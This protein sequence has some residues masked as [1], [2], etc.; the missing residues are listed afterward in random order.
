MYCSKLTPLFQLRELGGLEDIFWSYRKDQFNPLIN[1]AVSLTL[2]YSLRDNLKNREHLRN[3]LTE[4]QHDKLL[5]R[6]NLK[7]NEPRDVVPL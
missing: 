1:E 7:L 5:E 2:S 3:V 4:T 6:M